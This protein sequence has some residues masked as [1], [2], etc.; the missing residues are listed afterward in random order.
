[1]GTVPGMQKPLMKYWLPNNNF[2]SYFLGVTLSR[3]LHE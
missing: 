2:E 1:M 3:L